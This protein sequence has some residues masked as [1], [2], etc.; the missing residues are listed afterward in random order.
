MKLVYAVP[1]MLGLASTLPHHADAKGCLQGAAL[2]A[3]AGHYVHHTFLGMFGGCVGGRMVY[4]MYARWKRT[5]PNG[6]MSQFVDEH[7]DD[8]PPGWSDRLQALAPHNVPAH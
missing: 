4:K 2:G 3:V 5:H 6:T 1:V 8:L 7:R